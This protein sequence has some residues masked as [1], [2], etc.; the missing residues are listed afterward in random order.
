MRNDDLLITATLFEATGRG[1]IDLGRQRLDYSLRP[2]V[3]ENDVTGGLS[4][5]VRIEGPWS[6]LRIYPDLEAVARERLELEEEKL[7]AEAEARLEAERQRVEDRAKSRLEEEEQKLEE[8][9][10]NQLRK[11]LGRLFD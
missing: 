8:R 1:D 4:I 11:G 9:L 10:Q 5:P 6:R 2:R 7:R 3:F